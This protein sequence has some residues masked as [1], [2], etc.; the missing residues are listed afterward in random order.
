MGK[1]GADKGL[2]STDTM[3]KAGAHIA[4]QNAMEQSGKTLGSGSRL[5]TVDAGWQSRMIAKDAG[6]RTCESLLELEE[7]FTA[8]DVKVVFIPMGAMMTE[9]DIEKVC[10][11]HGTT[12]T[13]FKEVEKS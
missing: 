8:P 7:A 9:G 5:F 11:R 1:T 2:L 13:I 10:A 12:R 6:V 4:K 3:D